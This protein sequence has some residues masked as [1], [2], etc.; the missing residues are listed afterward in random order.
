M[1]K[2]QK[3]LLITYPIILFAKCAGAV[4]KILRDVP[5]ELKEN[6]KFLAKGDK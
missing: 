1:T 2:D 6:Y 4:G 5:K 3:I